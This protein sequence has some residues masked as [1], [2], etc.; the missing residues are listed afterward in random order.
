ML[1][2]ARQS[3]WNNKS[4]GV[5]H[6]YIII[7]GCSTMYYN[8]GPWFNT[9]LQLI[10]E[11]TKIEGYALLSETGGDWQCILGAETYDNANDSIKIRR[12]GS[13][14]K[15][16]CNHD[17]NASFEINLDEWFYFCL[18]RYSFKLNNNYTDLSWASTVKS[19][20][21]I[22]GG[23]LMNGEVHLSRLWSGAIGLIRFFE[24]EILVGEYIPVKRKIDDLCG[25]YD[26]VTKQFF[27]SQSSI[28]F[29][30][31]I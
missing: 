10:G 2:G 26:T 3:L 18:D 20:D 12:V 21:I 5:P 7:N 24:N 17:D 23:Q 29:Y 15:I 1:L 16:C 19:P 4:N 27:S 22:I 25:F 31:Y 14:L 11:Y 30:E 6:E 13:D 8:Y 9:G 28:P